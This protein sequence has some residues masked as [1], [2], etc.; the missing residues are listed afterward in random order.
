MT[1]VVVLLAF[2]LVGFET[3]TRAV[4]VNA[5]EPIECTGISETP[6]EANIAAFE[7]ILSYCLASPRCTSLYGQSYGAKLEQFTF[8][9]ETTTEFTPPLFLE[10]PIEQYVCQMNASL[11]ELNAALWLLRLELDL[12]ATGRACGL[13]EQPLFDESKQTYNCAPDPSFKEQQYDDWYALF[14]IFGLLLVTGIFAW[15][16]VKVFE[17]ARRGHMMV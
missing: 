3:R 14:V 6:L 12:V 13:G 16:G 8:L 5:T 7:Q 10:T 4:V 1:K 17:I 15:L 9:L 2:V 11:M